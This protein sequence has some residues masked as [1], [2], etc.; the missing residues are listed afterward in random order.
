MTESYDFDFAWE[1][2][3]GCIVTLMGM[4]GRREGLVLDL[5][6]G[7]GA[8]AEP[9]TE[10][11]LT[12]VG[13][14]ISER[15][16]EVLRRRGFE[17][18]RLDLA[19]LDG[20]AERLVKIADGRPVSAI[21]MLD[22]LEHLPDPEAFLAAL[23][24]CSLMLDH[25]L[26]GLSVPNVGHFD[27]GAKLVAGIW[28]VT[29][30]GLLDRTHLQFFT[31]RRLL[32][33]LQ[34]AGWFELARQDFRLHHS[35]QHFPAHHPM[36]ADGA[37]L[38]DLLWRLRTRVGDELSINQFVRLFVF[39]STPP[40]RAPGM[41]DAPF[42][43]VLVRTVGTRMANLMEALTC[44]AAQTDDDLEVLLLVHSSLPNV[45]GRVRDLVQTFAPQFRGRVHLYQVPDGGRA[46]PLNIGLG[47]AR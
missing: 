18:H 43:S 47:A 29:P 45:V 28:D 11:G 5:G 42:L 23:R 4:H 20:L 32:D 31:E 40:P 9:L 30:T 1:S 35:D 44:L 37:P 15:A 12:Y 8:V 41:V 46:R 2:S 19:D 17:T 16:L 26:L 39:A 6:C 24:S 7:S 33:M 27:V 36:L 25:P 10:L 3:Y 14:D 21:L 22:A 13:C 38:R 34:Y